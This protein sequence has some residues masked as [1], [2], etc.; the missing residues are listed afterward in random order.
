[1]AL[2][3][4]LEGLS[5]AVEGQ[6]CPAIAQAGVLSL[7]G[8]VTVRLSA[9]SIAVMPS[10]RQPASGSIRITYQ[11]VVGVFDQL[12]APVVLDLTAADPIR[13]AFEELLEEIAHQCPGS[14]VMI[15]T[16]ARCW[17]IRFLRRCC[18]HGTPPCWA[19]ALEDVRLVRVIGVMQDHLHHGFT[20]SQ[21]AEL[22][23]MSRSV[24]AARFAD[25]LGRSPMEFLQALRLAR[26]AELLAGTDL[27]V[28]MVA[29][30]V[31]YSSRSSFTRA[32]VTHLGAGPTAFRVAAATPPPSARAA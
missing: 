18:E 32:F 25:V 15:E 29:A 11:G 23:G 30:R 6:P 28:K 3:R 21:F 2:E 24:F 9:R 27:P 20:L 12:R 10:R 5:V 22:A 13:R 4:L 14:R 31:G 7:A 16:L 1:M 17:A 26:A 8:G 19:A